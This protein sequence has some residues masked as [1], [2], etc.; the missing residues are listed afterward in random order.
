MQISICSFT[1]PFLSFQEQEDKTKSQLQEQEETMF[2]K[3]E[4]LG[5]G[6][7]IIEEINFQVDVFKLSIHMTCNACI[8][9]KILTVAT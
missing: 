6:W 5:E 7:S 4:Q 8:P 3:Q 2:E 1:L 9:C